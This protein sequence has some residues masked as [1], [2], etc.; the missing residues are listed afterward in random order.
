MTN[1]M[2]KTIRYVG[3]HGIVRPRDL[4]AL[5]IP[6]EYLLRLYRRGKLSRTARG[7]YTLPDAAITERH[8]YAEVTK[9]VPGAVICL[10]TALAFHEITTQNSSSIWIALGKGARTPA[11]ESLALRIARL[12]G[13]PSQKGSKPI[14]SRAFPSVFTPPQR[15]LRTALS[16]ATR[17]AW[18]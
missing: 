15:P 5:G 2:M 10:L 12:S 11:L 16:F 18:T 13:H 3:K 7:V 14:V 1:N 8:S 9:R 17:L 6:R 4:E